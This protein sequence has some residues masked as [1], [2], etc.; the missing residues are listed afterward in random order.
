VKRYPP[1]KT[2]KRG[3]H[4]PYAKGAGRAP[5]PSLMA[6]L[7]GKTAGGQNPMDAKRAMQKSARRRRP[8][9]LL[10]SLKR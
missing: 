1:I 3:G 2:V 9:S 4:Q 10:H 7:A 5:G 8:K 6:M